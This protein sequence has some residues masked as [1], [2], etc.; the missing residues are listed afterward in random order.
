MWQGARPNTVHL[1][2]MS[3][4]AT[5]PLTVKPVSVKKSQREEELRKQTFLKCPIPNIML[6]REAR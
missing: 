6:N 3:E 1:S 4:K 5:S 2:S